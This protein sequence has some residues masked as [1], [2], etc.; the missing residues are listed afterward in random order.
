MCNNALA[1]LGN[2]CCLHFLGRSSV[3]IWGSFF[4]PFF[5]NFDLEDTL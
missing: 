1:R 3:L 5:V 2:K 4:F